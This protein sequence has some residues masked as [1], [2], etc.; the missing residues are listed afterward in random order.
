MSIIRILSIFLLVSIAHAEDDPANLVQPPFQE[1]AK[2]SPLSDQLEGD[3][4]NTKTTQNEPPPNSKPPVNPTDDDVPPMLLPESKPAPQKRPSTLLPKT[5]FT[6]KP[7]IGGAKTGVVIKSRQG[8]TETIQIAQGKLN[9]I[10]TPYQNPKVLTVDAV[11]TRVDG[12]AVYVATE[13]ETPVSLFISDTDTGQAISLQLVPNQLTVPAEIRIESAGSSGA[14]NT[15]TPM[16]GDTEKLFGEDSDYITELK[17]VMQS[18]AKQLVPQ[19]FTMDE[20]PVSPNLSTIC[21]DPGLNYTFGQA[22]QGH[23]SHIVILV[24]KNTGVVPKQI[25]EADCANQGVIAVSAWPKVRLNPGEKTEVYIL[26]R[27]QA[28][29]D[30]EYRPSLL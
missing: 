26:I 21:H 20:N 5:A 12:P 22:M 25:Q 30:H 1:I 6:K 14:L 3:D 17:S 4:Q 8:V 19:G 10:V 28:E 18:L 24:A 29:G 9:R 23:N 2:Q 15:G 11:E 7:E 27:N 16:S 13:S